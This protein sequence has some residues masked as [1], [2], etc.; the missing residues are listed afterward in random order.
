M[1]YFNWNDDLTT[2]MAAIDDQHR[3]YSK[4]VNAFL[5]EC[6]ERG[7]ERE[8]LSST[9]TFLR[10]YVIEHLSTE[11]KLMAEYDY[12]QR[13]QHVAQHDYLRGWTDET[14]DGLAGHVLDTDY[15]LKVNYVLVEWFQKHIKTV[16]KRLTAFLT[17]L[18]S[19][20]KLPKLMAL[21]K[22]ALGK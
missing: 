20:R 21:M 19:E 8:A 7:G 4:R 2:G 17:Q 18:A 5:R 10:Q 3:E 14:S 16:D 13:A 9:F 22:S 15:T 12:P 6:V 1:R 11:E